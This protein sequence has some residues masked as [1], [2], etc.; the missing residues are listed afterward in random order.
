MRK[1]C[2][3]YLKFT[4]GVLGVG[5]VL[6]FPGVPARGQQA[7]AA[8]APADAIEAAQ[9]SNAVPTNRAEQQKTARDQSDVFS[10][11]KGAD[12]EL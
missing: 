2:R 12:G 4:A 10:A 6:S 7:T 3:V 1:H 11:A 9:T 5:C 8:A